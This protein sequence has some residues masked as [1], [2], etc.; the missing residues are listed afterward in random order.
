MTPRSIL[1]WRHPILFIG[2]PLVASKYRTTV[3]LSDT[4]RSQIR[5]SGRSLNLAAFIMTAMS[6]SHNVSMGS[7]LFTRTP[8]P[9]AHSLALLDSHCPHSSLHAHLQLERIPRRSSVGQYD[10]FFGLDDVVASFSDYLV[11]V[12]GCPLKLESP[13]TLKIE[14]KLQH[15]IAEVVYSAGLPISVASAALILLK[16]LRAHIPKITKPSGLSGHRLFLAAFIIAAL[17]QSLCYGDSQK[18]NKIFGA[19][20][21]SKISMFSTREVD[22]LTSQFFNR[23]ED[24]VTVFPSRAVTLEQTGCPFVIKSYWSVAHSASGGNVRDKLRGSMLSG[25][26]AK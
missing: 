17:E 12:F 2:G 26:S 16:R 7:S 13:G 23:L 25:G 4:H 1:T 11:D 10:T 15:F 14:P 24:N 9:L 3:L 22:E 8:S 6:T 21:W 18:E 20:Y 19:S 5:Y